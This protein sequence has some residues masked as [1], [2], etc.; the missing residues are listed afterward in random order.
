MGDSRKEQNFVSAVV[1]VR[2]DENELTVFLQNIYKQ[3]SMKFTKFEIIC[4]N[5]ASDDKSVRVI[6]EVAEQFK[7]TSITI[8][9]LD[10]FHGVEMAMSAGMNLAIGD[11]VYEFD[12]VLCDFPIKSIIDV[13][14]K[15]LE[16][17]D[18][19]CAV[20]QEKQKKS[21]SFF[22]MLF[23][24]FALQEYH[25]QTERF[26]VLSRR[27]INRVGSINQYLPYRKAVYANCGLKM[28]SVTYPCVKRGNTI[29]SK[30]D[31]KQARYRRGLAID[32][33]ILF[34]EVGYRFSIWMTIVMM[35]VTI[36]VATYTVFVF[37][38]GIPVEGWTTTM[39]FLSFAFFGLFGI[40]TIMIKYLSILVS[41][42][43]KKQ[44][45]VITDIRKINIE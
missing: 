23:E 35:A 2:N 17:Y 8:I 38:T 30:E 32:S 36:L 41:L 19:V 12:S 10:H 3:L 11:F 33:L 45:Y 16:G 37:L 14:E 27:V 25:M 9:Q 34:T 4:V 6:E 22:Y 5:D 21:S 13:Y 28:T 31:G 24:K 29:R 44:R 43:F 42:N 20:P 40:L 39:L 1:Y 26:R 7:D 15:A 18:I